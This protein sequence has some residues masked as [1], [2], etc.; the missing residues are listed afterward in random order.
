MVSLESEV[1]SAFVGNGE[2]EFDFF[3]VVTDLAIFREREGAFDLD[4]GCL[5]FFAD[6]EG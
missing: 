3:L 6:L 4:G 5:A 2:P 1:E